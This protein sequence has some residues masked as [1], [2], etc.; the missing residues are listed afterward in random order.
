M[1]PPASCNSR[2]RC[3]PCLG[4]EILQTPQGRIDIAS[5]ALRGQRMQCRRGRRDELEREI[6][7][8][9]A[10][11]RTRRKPAMQFGMLAGRRCAQR[12]PVPV[13]RWTDSSKRDGDAVGRPR[14]A[15]NAGLRQGPVRGQL[16]RLAGIGNGQ[17]AADLADQQGRL[18]D[19]RGD[20]NIRCA[21]SDDGDCRWRSSARAPS[22]ANLDTERKSA[23]R[24]LDCSYRRGRPLASR[25]RQPVN[26]VFGVLRGIEPECAPTGRQ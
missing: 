4:R 17:R 25:S 18:I 9:I 8:R 10:P 22:A 15:A 5:N 16:R 14:I 3:G 24:L 11:D 1:R 23:D 26:R 2:K 7:H 13:G 12:R 19:L 6:D 20:Q 21:V